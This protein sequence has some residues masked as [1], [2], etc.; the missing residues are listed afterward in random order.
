MPRFKTVSPE[1][2][3]RRQAEKSHAYHQRVKAAGGR[4]ALSRVRQ[5]KLDS[6]LGI[7]G[8]TPAVLLSDIQ[9]RHEA[10]KLL[11]Q[12]TRKH[13]PA[14]APE[15]TPMFHI[16]FADD[17]GLASDLEPTL[18]FEALK[19]KV[20]KAIRAMG[21]SA[22]VMVEVQALTNFA[23]KDKGRTLM[24]HAHA[25]CWG[26]VSRRRFR[27]AKK[28]LNASRSWSNIFGAKPIVS[29]RLHHGLDDALKIVCYIAK[30]PHDAKYMVPV[31]RISG[32][33]FRF[34]PTLKGYTG[35]LA[36][37]IAEGL[38]HYTVFDAVFGVSDGK[39]IRK[40][41]KS[42]LIAWQRERVSSGAVQVREFDVARFWRSVRGRLPKERYRPFNLE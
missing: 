32:Q 33:R 1:L 20:D 5:R 36:L 40:E 38:S 11:F 34:K 42:R 30:L 31:L 26:P 24:L 10:A 21:L 7:D 35:S 2:T 6:L 22:V 19:R 15:G 27:G 39:F 8:C 12:M 25:L 41:W 4:L 13:L 14:L 28:K 23:V 37:R 16:T 9:A 3:L 18:K 17:I 29:R